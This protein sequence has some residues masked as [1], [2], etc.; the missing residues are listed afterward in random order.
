M[1]NIPEADQNSEDRKDI[2]DLI[3]NRDI[4]N[5]KA[6]IDPREEEISPLEVEDSEPHKAS[7]DFSEVEAKMKETSR[8]KE[9]YHL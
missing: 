3:S 2:S 5:T 8:S 1:E 9:E 7:H 6:E 4:T